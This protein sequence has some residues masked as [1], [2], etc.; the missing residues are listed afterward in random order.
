MK[1]CNCFRPL[2][3]KTSL[4]HLTAEIKEFIAEPSLDEFSDILRC[5][6]RLIGGIFN[7]PEITVFPYPQIHIDKVQGRMNKHG[8]VRSERHLING[9]C[10]SLPQ[11]K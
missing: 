3:F 11:T 8:C 6:N 5:T 7:R 2:P 1:Y 9:K 4:G 10:P